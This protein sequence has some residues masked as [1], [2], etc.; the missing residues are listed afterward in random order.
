VAVLLDRV[1]VERVEPRI[2]L[3]T[4]MSDEPPEPPEPPAD[5]FRFK[6]E[7]DRE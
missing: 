7:P 2:V 4:I 1:L 6:M 5:A 3:P